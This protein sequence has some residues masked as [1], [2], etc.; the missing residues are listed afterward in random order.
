[1][2]RV[3]PRDSYKCTSWASEVENFRCY[4]DTS[5]IRVGASKCHELQH[6]Q[7]GFIPHFSIIVIRH[8]SS[9]V[10]PNTSKKAD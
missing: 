6:A 3:N 2:L 4:I 1:M 10:S 7:C 5:Q 9:I 8:L